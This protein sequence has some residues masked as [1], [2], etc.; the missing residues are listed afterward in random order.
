[1]SELQ[2]KAQMKGI[3][4]KLPPMPPKGPSSGS[5]SLSL[6]LGH[7]RKRD[8]SQLPWSDY[9]HSCQDVEVDKDNIFRVYRRGAEGPVVLFL[10]G[11]GLSSLSWAVLA[12]LVTKSVRCQCLAMD[13]RGHGNTVTPNEHDLS[14]STL[15]RDVGNVITALYGDENVPPIIM[16]GH[17]MGGAIAIHAAVQFLV[18]SLAGLI[19]IDVVEG[20]AMEA[21]QGMQSFLRGRPKQFRSL[22]YAIEWAVKSG[23]IRNLESARVSMVG[24]LKRC[25]QECQ[26]VSDQVPSCSASEAI[27]EEDE[28]L[29]NPKDA[30]S[31][32][33]QQEEVSA[34][35]SV[36]YTWRVD[37]SKSE[38]YW[39]GW[40]EGMSNL[41]L[42]CAVPKM[43]LIA[44][45]DRLDKDLIVG[46][47]QGKFWMQVLPQCGHCVHE[48][49]PQKVADILASFL[50]RN[51]LAE[52]ADE[53]VRPSPAC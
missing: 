11:G 27:A 36:P 23:Q 46:Q 49:Q 33:Q 25:S 14:A 19:V 12:S 5:R 6:R 17:S 10:H 24:Q 45:V 51:K 9:F 13:F 20:T 39:K 42:S 38:T 4:S 3:S 50:V 28:E 22:E 31:P 34:S 40:F 26:T 37:L 35:T 47:M 16:V 41:F 1:M 18:P 2:R 32:T 8:F 29:E 44:G 53:F 21:L 48:D 30:S 43:L 7:P 15:A 52:A